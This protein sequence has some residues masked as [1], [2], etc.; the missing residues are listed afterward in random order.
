MKKWKGNVMNTTISLISL[1][2]IVSVLVGC[3]SV[4][5]L[6]GVKRQPTSS[7][8]IFSAGSLPTKPY[9]EIAVFSDR[10]NPGREQQEFHNFVEKAKQL[11]ANGVILNPTKDGGYDS[12]LVGSSSKA[13]YSATAFVWK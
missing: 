3:A 5:P 1:P 12:G 13:V 11:G 8:E 6:D 10:S 2:M 7:L 9:K 4:Q